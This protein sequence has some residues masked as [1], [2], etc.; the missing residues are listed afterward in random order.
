MTLR[1]FTAYLDEAD[2]ITIE[3]AAK[4]QKEPLSFTLEEK[5]RGGDCLTTHVENSY[6][7]NQTLVYRLRIEEPVDLDK[8]YMVIDDQRNAN[9]LVYRNVVRTDAFDQHFFAQDEQLGAFYQPNQTLF[10]VWAPISEEV[11]LLI[12]HQQE[13]AT[14]PL[15]KKEKGVWS[16]TVPGDYDGAAYRYLHLV[17]GQ[18][19]E[20]HDPYALSS[21]VNSG[22]SVVINPDKLLPVRRVKTPVPKTQ[23]II[24]E[25]SVRDFS[26]QSEAGFTAPSQFLGLIESPTTFSEPIGFDYL[27]QL[28]I[29]HV[30]L[31]PVADFGS[32]DETKPQLHYNWGYDPAQYNVPEGSFA[33]NPHDPYA[34]MLEL[35]TAIDHYHQHNISVIMDVVY[36]HVYDLKGFVFEQIVPGY[37]YRVDQNHQ[38][39]DGSWCGN[40][41]ASQRLMMRKYILDSLQVWL[42]VYGMDGFRFD[43]MGLLDIDTLNEAAHRLQSLYP[44]VYLYGEGWKMETGLAMENLAHQEHAHH[45]PAIGFFNDHYRDT[46]KRVLAHPSPT[47]SQE[48]RETI[49]NL[50]TASIGIH[51]QS[52]LYTDPAQSVHYLECHD[53]ATLFDYLTAQQSSWPSSQIEHTARF[54]LQIQ[55]LS[56]GMAF[57][58][59]GQEFF[60]TKH[61]MDNTYNQPDS[62]NQLDWQRKTNYQKEVDFV[63]QL[64]AFR[65]QHPLL[66]LTTA[67]EIREA[68]QF[69]WLT[70]S[71]L[72]YQLQDETETLIILFN[73]SSESY[74]YTNW[75]GASLFVHY[76]HVADQGLL[77][78]IHL[79]PQSVVLL[80]QKTS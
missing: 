24:Y 73:F 13:K 80:Q 40:D 11:L 9:P 76:P 2:I 67:D 26:A 45:L 43:L 4:W 16:L 3:L 36:N 50:L 56:Q 42:E 32:I 53:N 17:N 22:A 77:E 55:L 70:P 44:P 35:Q 34:R 5:K 63:R 64:I 1:R 66:S 6:L 59:S 29:T 30:Q 78:T 19:K 51:G 65:K 71:V 12:N 47:L 31:M 39:T 25:M 14:Y 37:C 74:L 21:L 57:L 23:A 75:T 38:K 41:L 72:S 61:G 20:F 49:Q 33:S 27:R 79:A 52:G 54:G 15:Q 60:R 18:W 48:D 8:R 46:F 28:G 10:K 58:H 62:I 68:C 69:Y 7:S